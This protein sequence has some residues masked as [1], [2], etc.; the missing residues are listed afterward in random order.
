[1]QHKGLTTGTKII[2]NK[3]R[4]NFI[5]ISLKTYLLIQLLMHFHSFIHSYVMPPVFQRL[6]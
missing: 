6:S 4:Y 2:Q 5:K 3:T 1:M